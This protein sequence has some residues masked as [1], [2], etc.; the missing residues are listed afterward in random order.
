MLEQIEESRERFIRQNKQDR[1]ADAREMFPATCHYEFP[2]K[3]FRDVYFAYL[4]PKEEDCFM[5][6][7]WKSGEVKNMKDAKRCN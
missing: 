4:P 1:I 7:K 5:F 3:T 6:R 2:T